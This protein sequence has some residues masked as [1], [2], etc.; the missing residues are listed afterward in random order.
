MTFDD[1][2]TAALAR[3]EAGFDAMPAVLAALGA[4]RDERAG[5]RENQRPR[6]L[7]F[8]K[9]CLIATCTAAFGGACVRMSAGLPEPAV[10]YA[11]RANFEEIPEPATPYARAMA[12]P[13][14]GGQHPHDGRHIM[15]M[16]HWGMH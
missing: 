10:F 12:E 13:R 2:V 8:G 1:H 3:H 11:H 16:R 4:L 14:M 9:P 7:P 6:C 5:K 15:S